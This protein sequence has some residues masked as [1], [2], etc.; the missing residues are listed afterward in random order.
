MNDSMYGYASHMVTYDTDEIRGYGKNSHGDMAVK[1]KDISST[2]NWWTVTANLSPETTGFNVI[3]M[4]AAPGEEIKVTLSGNLGVAGCISGDEAL[5]G[6]RYGF[7]SYNSD[8]SRTYGPCWSATDTQQSWT[9]PEN[10]SKVWFVVTG[11]PSDY[12]RHAWTDE[13]DNKDTKWPWKA[14]FENAKPYGK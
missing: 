6:W 10:A 9:V 5:A 13:S 4:N 11:A 3:R 14:S 8:G 2:D 12:E 1:G 7:V